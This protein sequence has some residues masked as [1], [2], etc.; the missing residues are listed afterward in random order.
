MNIENIKNSDEV[1]QQ[2]RNQSNVS[3]RLLKN[4]S[5]KKQER[6]NTTSNTK[7]TMTQQVFHPSLFNKQRSNSLTEPMT[8]EF[9]TATIPIMLNSGA[10]PNKSDFQQPTM[11]KLPPTWQ[12][13]PSK[14][15]KAS[16]LSPP[17]TAAATQLGNRFS[18]LPIDL[19]EDENS[20]PKF[21]A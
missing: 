7:K 4:S 12:R 6:G 20:Q 8:K 18:G 15:R 11:E 13:V 9:A 19:L 5:P 16:E 14:K 17:P 1:G 2:A 3:E 10:A 21:P